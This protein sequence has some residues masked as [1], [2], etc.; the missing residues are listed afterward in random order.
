MILP[1]TGF[2][3]TLIPP[4]KIIY[5]AKIP[6]RESYIDVFKQGF[7]LTCIDPEMTPVKLLQIQDIINLLKNQLANNLNLDKQINLHILINGFNSSDHVKNKVNNLTGAGFNKK[8]LNHKRPPLR[9]I[10]KKYK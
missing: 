1:F 8:R 5:N 9:N 4:L 6:I 7:I 2:G 10:I 3:Y